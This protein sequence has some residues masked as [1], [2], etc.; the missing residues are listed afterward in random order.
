M[1]HSNIGIKSIRVSEIDINDTIKIESFKNNLTKQEYDQ[2]TVEAIAY[3]YSL[4][5]VLKQHM[6]YEHKQARELYD[7]MSDAFKKQET[8]YRSDK[9]A[10]KT[11]DGFERVSNFYLLMEK[12]YGSLE[13]IYDKKDF[14]NAVRRSYEHKMDYRR[15][16]YFFHGAYWRWFEY[17]FLDLTSKYGDSFVRW[18]LTALVFAFICAGGFYLIDLFQPDFS[19]HTVQNGHWFDY[20]YFSIVTVTSLGFGD[21]VPISLLAK[22][23]T[24]L[25]VFFG[26]IM[27]GM[28]ITLIQKKI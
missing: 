9:K 14:L 20:I 11:G 16:N 23:F 13:V 12:C 5:D 22:I 18:G 28:F 2:Y 1:N 8:L 19:L 4:R 21:I 26:Y 10:Y 24:S 17:L 27:L 3:Y 7:K 6:L 25:E 15:K